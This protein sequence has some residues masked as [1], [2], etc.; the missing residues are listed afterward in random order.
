VVEDEASLRALA[1]EVLDEAGLTVVALDTVEAAAIYLREHAPDVA[2]VFTDIS[3]AGRLDGVDLAA[4]ISARWPWIAVVI[5]S[6]AHADRL[7]RLPRSIR[8]LPK[9]WRVDDLTTAATHALAD[10]AAAAVGTP[11]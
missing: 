3:L 5:T 11:W 2:L 8:F 1:T 7:S 4:C 9:P 6:G 10:P